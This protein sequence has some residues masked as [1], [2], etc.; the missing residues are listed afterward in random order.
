MMGFLDKVLK[1]VG[2]SLA[3]R[4]GVIAS[5]EYNGFKLALGN[6]PEKKVSS[7]NSA[8]QII[9]LNEND[10]VARFNIEEDVKEVNYLETIKFPATGS[11]GYRC[12]I[13]FYNGNSFE[14]DLI[15]SKILGFKVSLFEKMNEESKEFFKN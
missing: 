10:E 14:V 9:I 11:D 13:I 12:D 15:P 1:K 2:T 8:S 6:P 7:A 3:T 5:G 4:Y